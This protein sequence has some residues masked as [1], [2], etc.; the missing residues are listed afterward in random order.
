MRKKS[1]RVDVVRSGG[2][3]SHTEFDLVRAN[4]SEGVALV[5]CRPITGRTHQIRVHLEKAG[6]PIVGD[7]VYGNGKWRELS[8]ALARVAPAH[9]FLHA[10]EI[11]FTP[12]D[13]GEPIRF[14]ATFPKNFV[15]IIKR[16]GIAPPK[17]LKF[18]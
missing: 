16:T 7:K 8:P 5:R 17:L 1:R 3:P 6:S 11:E 14:Y 18:E 12:P 4:R 2:Q 15:N 13:L 10:M 9:Q